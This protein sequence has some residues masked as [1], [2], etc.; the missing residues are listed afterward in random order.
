MDKNVTLSLSFK[1]IKMKPCKINKRREICV[2]HI[3]AYVNQP[4]Y[5]NINEEFITR[6]KTEASGIEL[7]IMKLNGISNGEITFLFKTPC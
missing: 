5:H 4:T 2:Q 1:Y 3:F 6:S 7:Q